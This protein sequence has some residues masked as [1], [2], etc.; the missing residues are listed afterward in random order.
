MRECFYAVVEY[1]CIGGIINAAVPCAYAHL[2]IEPFVVACIIE[3]AIV[4][5]MGPQY[6]FSATELLACVLVG[7]DDHLLEVHHFAWFNT[8]E[9]LSVGCGGVQRTVF[10][11]DDH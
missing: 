9:I 3:V 7:A 1:G 6:A 10:A 5:V 11:V 4:L 8:F 2:S